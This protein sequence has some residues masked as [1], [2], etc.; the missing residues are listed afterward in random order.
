MIYMECTYEYLLSI[1]IGITE[2]SRKNVTRIVELFIR[3]DDP[4][5]GGGGGGGAVARLPAPNIGVANIS[6]CPPPP[7]NN[8][9][10]KNSYVMQE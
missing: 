1:I 9:D 6:F 2:D 10:L 3:G 8:F 5:G 4:G 7:P